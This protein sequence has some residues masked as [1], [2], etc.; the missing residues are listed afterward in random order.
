M[1]KFIKRPELLFSA[2][3]AV[4][5]IAGTPKIADALCACVDP[6]S[7]VMLHRDGF[8]NI[9][10]TTYAASIPVDSLYNLRSD[11]ATIKAYLDFTTSSTFELD[12]KVCRQ[13]QSGGAAACTSTQKWTGGAGVFNKNFNIAS[14]AATTNG[15]RDGYRLWVHA[16]AG[17]VPDPM[18]GAVERPACW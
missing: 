17:G 11:A 4:G 14:I 16:H 3:A 5:G 18:V 12:A 9:N 6:V 7:M 2:A 15:L 10:G 1:N 8:K 13:S